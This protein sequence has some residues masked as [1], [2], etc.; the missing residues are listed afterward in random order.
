[1]IARLPREVDLA[2]AENMEISWGSEYA[3]PIG[4]LGTQWINVMSV[5]GIWNT[6]TANHQS[7]VT[8]IFWLCVAQLSLSLLPIFINCC[9]KCC[10][11]EQDR[12]KR[13]AIA[14]S[15]NSFMSLLIGVLG[16]LA[17]KYDCKEL[18]ITVVIMAAISLLLTA[19]YLLIVLCGFCLYCRDADGCCDRVWGLIALVLQVVWIGL[20]CIIDV[21]LVIKAWPFCF[22]GDQLSDISGN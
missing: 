10:A 12:N 7:A 13:S 6:I 5:E 3:K 8:T 4:K 2:D 18:L 20:A 11:D 21:L 17:V 14:G 1:M 16:I 22:D 9:Q 15:G 19:I